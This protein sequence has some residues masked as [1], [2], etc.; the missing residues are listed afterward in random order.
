MRIAIIGSRTYEHRS[1]IRD[2]IL[3]LKQNVP[4]LTIVS[5]GCKTGADHYAKKYAIDMG[6]D[7]VEYNPAHTPPNL[8]SGMPDEYYNKEYHPSQFIHRNHLIV[9]NSDKIIAFLDTTSK[10]TGTI[11]TIKYAEKLKKP[12]V[13][14]D[15][16]VG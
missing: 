14:I 13:V 6:I 2:M 5:G 8:Y 1:K 16:K 15:E 11:G 3:K 12:V 7:Y 9:Y 4:D 10:S